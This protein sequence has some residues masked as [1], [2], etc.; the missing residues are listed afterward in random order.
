METLSDILSSGDRA[1]RA[2]APFVKNWPQAR[3]SLLLID[4]AIGLERIEAVGFAATFPERFEDLGAREQ[5]AFPGRGAYDAARREVVRLLAVT[6]HGENPWE[7]LRALIRKAGRED[8]EVRLWPLASPAKRAGLTP[9]EIRRDWVWSLE[10]ERRINGIRRLFHDASAPQAFQGASRK[11]LRQ[12]VEARRIRDRA[13]GERQVLRKAAAAFDRLFDIE[14]IVAADLLPPER[15]GAPP[16]YD[17]LGRRRVAL[18]PKLAEIHAAAPSGRPTRLAEVWQAIS[19]SEAFDLPAD[20]SADDLLTG[21]T[22]S[23]VEALPASVIGVQESSWTVYRQLAKA[24]LRG[25]C[26]SSRLKARLRACAAVWLLEVRAG[27]YVGRYSARVRERI[28]AQIEAGIGDGDAVM[29][30]SAPTDQGFAFRTAGRNR[31]T[32]IDFDGMTLVRFSPLSG[33]TDQA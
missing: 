22:W 6:G 30:W 3:A 15:I 14:E 19:V 17:R 32:P 20:P 26:W 5:S 2:G 27:V 1:D 18:P 29:C 25:Q 11:I 24:V 7:A 31:R 9:S 10:A 23:K 16:E 28:W 12:V 13:I 8:L 4:R 21:D 33:R